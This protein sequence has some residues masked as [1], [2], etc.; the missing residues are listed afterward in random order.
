MPADTK[1]KKAKDGKKGDDDDDEKKE[2]DDIYDDE[3]SEEEERVV[4]MNANT[5]SIMDKLGHGDAAGLRGSGS[6]EDY[7][8]ST[9]WL[10]A[11]T[12]KLCLTHVAAM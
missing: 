5:V 9:T 1:K 7:G 3:M 12:H 2:E 6:N 4:K 11:H 8:G 10:K